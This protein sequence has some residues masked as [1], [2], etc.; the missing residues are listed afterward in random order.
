MNFIKQCFDSILIPFKHIINL[1]FSTG[2]IPSQL[3]IA[4]V[5]PIYKSGDP[6]LLNNYRPISLLSNFSKILEKIM[7]NRLVN[8]I[9]HHNLLSNHQFGFRKNHSTIHPMILL[10]NFISESLNNKNYAIAIFCDLSKAFDTVDHT[11]LISKI[12][13]MGVGGTDLDW[14]KNYLTGRK[15]YVYVNGSSSTLRE[16][17][18]GVPQGSILGP[19]LFLIYINDLPECTT[20]YSL[21]FADDATLLARAGSPGELFE[22]ANR[23]FQKI[24]LFFRANR[25]SINPA[26]T[27]YM[28]F[29]NN[30]NVDLSKF[31]V[32][33]VNN[34]PNYQ[35]QVKTYNL[36]CISETSKT[37][38]VKFLGL[39]VAPNLNYK[40][41]VSSIRKKISNALYFLRSA[42]NTPDKKSLTALYYS[43]IHSHLIYAI[44]IWSC[45]NNELINSLYKLQKKQ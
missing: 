7:Y 37:P 33:I 34:D 41:H 2:I 28:L 10:D 29:T 44:Q 39:Y 43:L 21:L 32:T 19:L 35:N 45:C 4:K 42:K 12:K 16:I 26:K 5:V 24:T 20:L 17:L 38:A 1:S 23:E 14:F 18:L 8:H 30:K 15:Q 3:K 22:I 27:C 11:I 36:E 13:K 6:R 40:F 25:L 9:E 31:N